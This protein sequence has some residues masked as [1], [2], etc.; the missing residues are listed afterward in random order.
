MPRSVRDTPLCVLHPPVCIHPHTYI[1]TVCQSNHNSCKKDDSA[2]G[3]L[4][5]VLLLN[6]EAADKFG[7]PTLG[8]YQGRGA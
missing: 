1:C 7:R 5:A 3:E 8:F 4:H 6:D 2:M